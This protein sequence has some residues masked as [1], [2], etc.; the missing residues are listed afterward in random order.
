MIEKGDLVSVIDQDLDGIV[1]SVSISGKATVRCKDGMDWEFGS[2]ELIVTKAANP[3][4]EKPKPPPVP[5]VVRKPEPKVEAQK[6]KPLPELSLAFVANNHGS[7]DLQLCNHSGYHILCSVSQR[8]VDGWEN[9]FCGKLLNGHHSDLAQYRRGDLNDIGSY[10]VE[11]VF[12]KIAAYQ[13]KDPISCE[14]KIRPKKFLNLENFKEYE[15]IEG[16]SMVLEVKNKP[17]LSVPQVTVSAPRKAVRKYR[18]LDHSTF[19]G[20]SK[21]DLHIELLVSDLGKLSAGEM[22]EIQKQA[23]VEALNTAMADPHKLSVTIVHGH[24]K[25]TLKREVIKILNDYGLSFNQDLY[26]RTGQAALEVK[27]K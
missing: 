13:Q 16:E 19:E 24:G 10:L 27:L 11:A 15:G 3:K 20:H 1:L 14:L 18:G 26:L 4:K 12:F 7:W 22:L 21:I 17:I 2:K 9:M 25:G 6:K 8:G 5:V 23:C